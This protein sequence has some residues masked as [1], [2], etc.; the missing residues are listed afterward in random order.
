MRGCVFYFCPAYTSKLGSLGITRLG[1]AETRD[2]GGGG[3]KPL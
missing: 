2:P 1:S 3:Y